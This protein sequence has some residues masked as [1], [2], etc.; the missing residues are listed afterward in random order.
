MEKI[1]I[2]T[3][4]RFW[5]SSPSTAAVSHVAAIRV[6]LTTRHHRHGPT[7]QNFTVMLHA[8]RGP[9]KKVVSR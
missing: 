9:S 5:G 7:V 6:A 8:V 4:V 3:G 2:Q 1:V